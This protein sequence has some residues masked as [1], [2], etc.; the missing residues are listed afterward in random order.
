MS[1]ESVCQFARSWVNVV[2]FHTRLFGVVYV[3]CGN[4]HGGSEKCP[5]PHFCP[6]PAVSREIQKAV[7]PH[8]P[9][10][11]ELTPCEFF[12][13]PKI[14]LNLEGRRFDT[15]EEIQAKSQRV[16]DTLTEK[17]FQ[18]AFQQWRRRWDRCLHAGGN[19][20]EGDGGRKALR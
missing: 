15:I 3:T 13:F 17:D 6:H 10:S 18:E 9:Y 8:P 12:L 5:V 7:I 4:F 1:S 20:F 16:L 19:Y 11:L 14:K 2:I